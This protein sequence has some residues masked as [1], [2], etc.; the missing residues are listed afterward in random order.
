MVLFVVLGIIALPDI[1][2]ETLPDF[3]V[4]EVEIRIIYPGAAA[5]DV[6]EAICLPVEEAMDGVNDVEEIRCDAREGAATAVVRMKEGADIDRFRRRGAHRDG[7][8]RHPSGACRGAGHPPARAYRR[9]DLR[10]GERA[11]WTAASLKAYAESLKARL[12]ALDEVSLVAHPGFLRS[13]DPGARAGASAPPVRGEPCGARRHDRPAKREPAHRHHRDARAGH[14]PSLRRRASRGARARGPRGARERGRWIDPA[15]RHRH[16]ERSIRARRRP[17]RSGRRA[18][19]E[20]GRPQGEGAGRHPGG[21]GGE[22]LRR[23]GAPARC[24]GSHAGAHPG[25]R[26]GGERPASDARA[27]T[28]CRGSCSSSSRCGSSSACVSPSGSWRDCRCPSS[29]ACT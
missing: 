2:R 13:S 14:P 3:S 28:A 1:R 12:R 17:H 26:V 11:R 4:P 24:T 16:R 8:D 23:R 18:C 27:Q 10:H 22:A 5:R 6:E 29:A 9:R 20:A 25:R 19:G 15:R 21:G 7:S